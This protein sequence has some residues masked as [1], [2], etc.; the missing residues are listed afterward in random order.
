MLLTAANFPDTLVGLLP[1]VGHPV[2]Q[3]PEMGP[4]VIGD[5]RPVLVEE[6][7]RVHKFAVDVQLHL[8]VGAVPDADRARPFVSLKMIETFLGEFMTAVDPIHDL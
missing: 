1:I 2:G 3:P 4:K 8:A 6:V 5:G 7:D